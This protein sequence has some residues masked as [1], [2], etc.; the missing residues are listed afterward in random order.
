MINENHFWF[1]HK[2][3]FNFWK[4]IYGFKNHKSFSE[5][6]LFVLAHTF[7]IRLPEFGNGRSSESSDIGI[8]QHP[9]ARILLTPES[10]DIWPPSLDVDELDSGRIWSE[11]SHG[12][13]SIGSGQ[14]GRNPT[15]SGQNDRILAKMTGIRR[16][17]VGIR[18]FWPDPA[19]RAR[20][21]PTTATEH[22]LI[23]ATVT[24]SHFV[25]F[26]C[27]PNAKKYF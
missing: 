12:Q 15:G 7:D 16:I 2:T 9:A 8:R 17:L 20:R 22:C 14:N 4:T 25:I 3:F 5:I 11:F 21:N 13:K 6:K 24:F 1:D 23:S 26:S 18:Q 27:E 10:D 19:K